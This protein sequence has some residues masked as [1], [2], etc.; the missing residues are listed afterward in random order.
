M[1]EAYDR[2][3]AR[4][5]ARWTELHKKPWI[6]VSTGLLGMAA[7]ARD[8]LGALRHDLAQAG[9]DATVS[10]V[11]ST[12]LCYAEPLVDVYV[13]AAPRVLYANVGPEHVPEI[14]ERHIKNGHPVVELGLATVDSDHPGLPRREDLP[15]MR[16]QQRIALRN[17]GE[18]DP[19]DIDQYVARGGF[20]GLERAVWELDPE[21]VLQEVKDSGLRGRGGAAFPTGVKWGFLAGN[22]ASEKYILCN[23]EEGDPGAFNDKTILEAD[24]F[25]LIE[26]CIIAGFATGASNGIVFIRHGHDAPIERTRAAIAA[27]YANGLL[28]ERILGTDFAFEMDVSLVGESYVAGEET[29]LMEAI[30]GKRSMPRFRPPFPAA[31]GVWGK[32]SNINNIKTLAYVPEIVRQGAAW[33]K[34]IGTEK[35]SGTAIAC[36]SGDIAYPGLVEVPFGLTM[37][38]V[39]EE[40]G[41]GVPGGKALKFVQTGGPL[42]GVLPVEGLDML[43]DLD[44]MAEAG[45]MFGSGGLIVCNEDRSVVDLTRNLLAFD[46]MESCGKCFPCRLG[47]SHLLEVLDRLCAGQGGPEDMALME[48]IGSNMKVGSLCGHGQLGYNPVASAVKFFGPEFAAQCNP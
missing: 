11:G 20:A 5:S 37:R 35:S 12:G 26:G 27:C 17:A 40:C 13:P 22:P 28:G 46:Q 9:I 41:G 10:E 4:A 47:M 15:M 2:L 43:L 6:R 23:A 1:S 24:P 31:E 14:V 44:V 7:G 16:L 48:R 19:A 33:F 34:G 36:L 8:T 39:I 30:E 25:T 21:R 45:A 29:A 42:G 18:I 38:Q 3:K 32:P